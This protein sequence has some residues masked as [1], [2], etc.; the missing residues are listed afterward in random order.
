MQTQAT[1]FLDASGIAF[2]THVYDHDPNAESFGLEAAEKLGLDVDTVFKTL[3]ARLDGE[4]SALVVAI[5]PVAHKL[6]LKALARAAGAKRAHMAVVADAERSSGYVAGGISPFGQ[7]RSVATYVDE[8]AEIC[9][10][11]YVSGGQRGFD[12]GVSP[13]D[14]IRSL[15]AVTADLVAS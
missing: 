2:T 12:I 7:K 11:M 8:T 3:M 13:T 15:G 9:D 10:I 6:N 5:V 4:R 14:L 1:V